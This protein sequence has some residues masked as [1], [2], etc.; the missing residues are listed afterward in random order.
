MILQ[1][2]LFLS[3]GLIPVFGNFGEV[4]RNTV[5]AATDVGVTVDVGVEVTIDVDFGVT[6]DVDVGAEDEVGAEVDN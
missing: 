2:V 3:S 5:G 4:T 6:I 1:G